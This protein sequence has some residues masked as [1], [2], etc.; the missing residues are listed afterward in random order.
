MNINT[1]KTK[2]MIIGKEE[3]EHLIKLEDR[4]IQ[5]I[6]KFKYLG[7]VISWD[8]RTDNE[9]MERTAATGRVFNSIKTT[10]L[11]NKD[12]PKE[13]RVQIFKKVVIPILTYGSESWTTTEKH[14]KKI[15]AT[16][17]RFLRKIEGKTIMDHV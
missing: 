3:K 2:T 13:I 1:D 9:I 17:M 10:F 16:E 8:G 5:Q 4:R 12:I 6:E 15:Q 11:G 14:R 7:T